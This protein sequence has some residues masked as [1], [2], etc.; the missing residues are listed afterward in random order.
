MENRMNIDR[1]W[2]KLKDDYNTIKIPEHGIEGM[3]E[4]IERAKKEKAGRKKVIFFRKAGICAA[5]VL[6]LAILIPNVSVNAAMAME[7]IPVLGSVIRVI[8][9]GRYDFGDE[10]HEAKVEIPKVEVVDSGQ[11]NPDGELTGQPSAASETVSEETAQALNN[12]IEQYINSLVE[13]FKAGLDEES[14][15]SLDISYEVV[16]DTEEWFTLRLDVLEIQASGYMYSNYYHL[17]RKTGERMELGDLFREDAD[18]I[19]AISDNVKKQMREQMASD[20]EKVY[21]ID[22]VDVPVTDFEA[23]KKDQNF[24]FN[25]N[26][27]IVISFDEY[28]VAPGYMGIVQFTIPREVTDGLLK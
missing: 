8:T 4:A 25:D 9:F 18:Y 2:E 28:E 5:A 17:D 10:R 27:E 13:E 1:E 19:T 6:F 3:K 16:T 24:Y 12:D 26:G 23:I 22:S 11:G 7:K 20:D 14:V 21:F 15:K